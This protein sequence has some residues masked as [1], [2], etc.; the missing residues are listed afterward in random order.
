MTDRSLRKELAINPHPMGSME[1]HIYVTRCYTRATARYCRRTEWVQRWMLIPA[2]VIY[3]VAMV[4]L[5]VGQVR[6]NRS[7][8]E[9]LDVQREQL[10][11]QR[12]QM[13]R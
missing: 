5:V 1:S 2:L 13:K 10:Q 4:A 11:L 12:E 8:Q 6:L 7:R 9:L 3:T